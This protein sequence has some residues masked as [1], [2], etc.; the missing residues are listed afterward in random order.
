MDRFNDKLKKYLTVYKIPIAPNQ[1]DPTVFYFPETGQDPILLPGVHAQIMNDMEM[2]AG[3][4]HAARVKKIVIVGDAVK[5]GS[6]DKTKD[7][8]VIIVLN[9]DI[10]D[11]D[12][13]GVLAA[14]ILEKTKALSGKQAIGTLRK[15][16][17]VPSLRDIN[18][19]DYEGAYEVPIQQWLKLPSGIA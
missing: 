18:L 5:P 12:V 3:G 16:Q 19:A 17:Y 13:D 11:L 10:M 7:I 4:G 14:E 2:F 8:K 6:K 9:K 1:L 15:I